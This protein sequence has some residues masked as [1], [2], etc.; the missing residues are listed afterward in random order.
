VKWIALMISVSFRHGDKESL[1]GEIKA[2]FGN[3]LVEIRIVEDE[4][5]RES[6][7]YYCFVRIKEYD[8]HRDSLMDSTAVCRVVPVYD[9]PYEFTKEEVDE[10]GV[11]ADSDGVPDGFEVGDMVLICNGELKGLH[12]IITKQAENSHYVVAFRM[13]IRS[14]N[15]IIPVEDMSFVDNVFKH[16]KF[17]VTMEDVKT[18]DIHH[19]G[20]G[21]MEALSKI[22][23]FDKIHRK[24]RR[25]HKGSTR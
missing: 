21:M 20:K 18:G 15:K 11:S 8:S 22:V 4:V 14:F 9:R 3:D 19:A 1:V 10:F 17:P 5:M 25:S 7:E 13:C 23:N 16:L 6:G 2:I 12:G 24:K